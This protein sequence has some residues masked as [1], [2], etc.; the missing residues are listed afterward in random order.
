MEFN[1]FE[2]VTFTA[3]R[4][5]ANHN[6]IAS[7]V[8]FRHA[9]VLFLSLDKMVYIHPNY[10]DLA[11]ILALK[12]LLLL[13]FWRWHGNRHDQTGIHLARQLERFS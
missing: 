10:Y 2:P 7:I 11:F 5:G 12:K 3:S 9:N 1:G 13:V 6:T 4:Q 8:P